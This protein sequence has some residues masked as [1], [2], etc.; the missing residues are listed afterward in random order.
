MIKLTSSQILAF[1]ARQC[2]K[3]S[4]G[5]TVSPNSQS[6][7]EKKQRLC[8]LTKRNIFMVVLAS[9]ATVVFTLVPALLGCR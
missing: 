8:F 3:G 5:L 6:K 7:V 4:E 2:C 9:C 1:F